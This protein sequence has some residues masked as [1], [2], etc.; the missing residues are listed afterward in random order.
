MSAFLLAL[1]QRFQSADDLLNALKHASH[2]IEQENTEEDRAK[3]EIAKL[4]DF[5]NRAEIAADDAIQQS[6]NQASNLL[7]NELKHLAT[8][9]NLWHNSTVPGQTIRFLLQSRQSDR[10]WVDVSHWIR[11][12][13]PNR[14]TVGELPYV[15][16]C[17]D[18][19]NFVLVQTVPEPY[20][21][22]PSK[23]FQRLKYEVR[24]KAGEIFAD[25]VARLRQRHEERT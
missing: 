8:N 4:R 12:V 2:P 13:G 16:A 20:Y 7:L 18:Y 6:I 5:Y 10:I 9:Y 17:Y 21:T 25:L 22:G 11:L 1:R 14:A 3:E 19:V 15:E 23:D 24:K